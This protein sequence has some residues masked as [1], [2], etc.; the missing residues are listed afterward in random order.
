MVCTCSTVLI[1]ESVTPSNLTVPVSKQEKE[2]QCEVW[3]VCRMSHSHNPVFSPKTLVKKL[4]RLVTKEKN[5]RDSSKQ[6]SRCQDNIFL[7][8]P[9]WFGWVLWHINH[10]RLFNAKPSLYIYIKYIWFGLV[11]GMSTIVGFLMPN[12]SSLSLSHSLSRQHNLY[13]SLSH[14][15]NLFLT[16]ILSVSLTRTQSLS[17]PCLSCKHN[18]SHTLSLRQTQSLS[19]SRKHSLPLTLTLSRKDNLSLT[20]TLFLTQTQSLSF[21]LSLSLSLSLSYANTIS[22]IISLNKK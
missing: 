22:I 2:T 18:L 14:K 11:N 20:H 19:L 12:R 1:F 13:L 7:L 4:S 15:H 9:V 8:Y 21:Y 6:Q 10:F 5:S 16:L 17:P 3:W